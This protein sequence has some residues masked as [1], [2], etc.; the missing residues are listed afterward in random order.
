ML[1][2]PPLS[3]L[4]ATTA[5]AAVDG[6]S[7]NGGG[8]DDHGEDDATAVVASTAV[9]CSRSWRLLLLAL[10]ISLKPVN[11]KAP[12]PASYNPH[13]ETANRRYAK[14]KEPHKL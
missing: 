6:S 13:T 9:A 1:L 10:M 3:L 4:A 5:A 7:Q 11:S 12:T 2:L 14:H 8:G